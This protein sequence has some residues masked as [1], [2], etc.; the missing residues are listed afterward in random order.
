M[1]EHFLIDNWKDC[2]DKLENND[3]VGVTNHGGWWWGNFW[4]V[5]S[6]LINTITPFDKFYTGSRWT[7]ESW[8]HDANPNKESTKTHELNRFSYD[9]YYSILPK[10]FYDKTVDLKD[11]KIEVVYAEYGFFA[12]QRD[13]GR[14]LQSVSKM[15]IDVTENAKKEAEINGI[16]MIPQHIVNGIEDPAYGLDKQVRIK[17]KTNIDPE[18]EYIITSFNFWRISVAS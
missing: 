5:R 16:N 3:I 13:E 14:G 1:M 15:I 18:N 12:E 11:I 9:S 17:F 8:L 7:A 2:V 4:W 6:S 10:Y